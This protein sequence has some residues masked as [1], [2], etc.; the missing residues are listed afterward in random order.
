MATHNELGRLGEDEA[1]FYLTLK[2]YHLLDR[3]WRFEHY[4]IDIVAE[5][6]G[7]IVFVEVKT[8]S[9]GS[10]A[11]AM[12]AVDLKRSMTSLPQVVLT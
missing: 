11:A 12:E 2:G 4:E 8:R 3:N 1:L 10:T 6:H 5:W 7:E 9:Q